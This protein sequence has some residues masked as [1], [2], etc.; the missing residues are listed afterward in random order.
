MVPVLAF[1]NL[2][3]LDALKRSAYLFRKNWGEKVVGGFS[4]GLIFFLLSL[5]DFLL[6]VAGGMLAGRT[7]LV[8]GAVLMVLYFV[9]LA[10][11]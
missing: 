11:W 2:G 9:L 10:V 1:E 8:V 4:F 3:P 7:G 6:P 5:P